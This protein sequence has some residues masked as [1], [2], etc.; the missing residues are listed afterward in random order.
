RFDG[1]YLFI[2][3]ARNRERLLAYA[4]RF[5]AFL[6]R[7]HVPSLA[8]MTYT[9]Q[10]CREEMEER[11]AILCTDL[12]ELREKLRLFGAGQQAVSHLYHSNIHQ[13]AGEH[14]LLMSRTASHK[15]LEYLVQEKD[16]ERLAM[17]WIR[18]ARIAWSAL[19][20]RQLPARVRLPTYPF[21]QGRYWVPQT[22]V[23]SATP[24]PPPAHPQLPLPAPT[25]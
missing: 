8:G 25:P 5:R 24:S 3:S 2:L 22:P 16:Y 9:L 20:G 21:A 6:E 4:D 10:N 17:L 1:P 11:L 18:G 13:S 12:A 7:P 19:F 15:F 14:A 23:T